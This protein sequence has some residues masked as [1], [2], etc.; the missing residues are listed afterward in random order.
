[1]TRQTYI[2]PPMNPWKL[3]PLGIR[4]RVFFSLYRETERQNVLQELCHKTWL[5]HPLKAA[6]QNW[7]TPIKTQRPTCWAGQEIIKNAISLNVS[8]RKTMCPCSWTLFWLDRG[9][10]S[11][12]F[13]ETRGFWDSEKN[14]LG[15]QGE[16]A[17]RGSTE[18]ERRWRPVVRLDLNDIIQAISW[19]LSSVL[20]KSRG[21]AGKALNLQVINQLPQMTTNLLKNYILRK[22]CIFS[23]CFYHSD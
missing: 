17:A 12:L 8:D 9:F 10:E 20:Q 23:A 3:R 2:T 19:L 16:R 22:V 14:E 5:R 7:L 4:N 13:R 6:L 1:M 11:G 21:G 15:K 18:D